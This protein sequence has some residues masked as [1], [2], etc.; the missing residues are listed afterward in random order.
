MAKNTLYSVL[1]HFDF[2]NEAKEYGNGW[3]PCCEKLPEDGTS[4]IVSYKDRQLS[5]ADGTCEG[6]YDAPN[7]MWH[8]TDYEYSDNAEVI[9]WQPRLASYQKGG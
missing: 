7:K 6:W 3:I 1:K 2:D 4:V 8:L 9:A 5:S